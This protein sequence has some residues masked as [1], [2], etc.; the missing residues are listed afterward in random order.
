MIQIPIFY[1]TTEG[2]T[3][4]IAEQLAVLFREAGYASA[5]IDVASP[6]VETF[7]W[8]PVKAVIVGA[9]LHLGRH[10]AS[11]GR[12]VRDHLHRFAGRPSAFFSVSLSAASANPDEVREAQ[13][14]ALEFC[15]N[16]GWKPN[17]IVPLAGRLAYSK[18][19][20]L[21]RWMMK[22]IARKEGGPTDTTHDHELTDWTAVSALAGDIVHDA[23]VRLAS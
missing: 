1:A 9:S 17:R 3:A 21:K 20:W 23:D 18:Y 22:R 10:Q 4:R 16:A 6:R 2:Q 5:A 14:I 13:R 8:A 19:G 15:A 12:F 7:D 11:A